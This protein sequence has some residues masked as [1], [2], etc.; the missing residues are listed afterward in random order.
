MP[1]VAAGKEIP[2]AP[3]PFT[4]NAVG[5]LGTTMFFRTTL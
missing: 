5:T 2:N 4:T 3:N 1:G